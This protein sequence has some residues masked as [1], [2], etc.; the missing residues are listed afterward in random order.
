[1]QLNC[2]SFIPSLSLS[3]QRQRYARSSRSERGKRF[4]P[5]SN[6]FRCCNKRWRG[7]CLFLYLRLRI[8]T[9]TRR[10]WCCALCNYYML[11]RS[12][13]TNARP[14]APE[15][16]DEGKGLSIVFVVRC[17][18]CFSAARRIFYSHSHS[19]CCESE[20]IVSLERLREVINGIWPRLR[21]NEKGI[22]KLQAPKKQAPNERN[23]T[24]RS[25]LY[26]RRDELQFVGWWLSTRIALT[27]AQADRRTPTTSPEVEIEIVCAHMIFI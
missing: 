14:A 19:E 4:G 21:S 1:M 7:Y 10:H 6:C 24:G 18:R 12:V 13:P 15:R 20:N 8:Y 9:S 25:S 22:G 27:Q 23:S 16:G 2:N 11:N 17:E 3:V 5:I 26:E